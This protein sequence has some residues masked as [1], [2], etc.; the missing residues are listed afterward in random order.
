VTTG[1]PITVTRLGSDRVSV[2]GTPADCVRLALHHLACAPSWVLAG[3]NAG[4]N[5]GADI[6]HSGTV[7]AARE[8]AIHGVPAIAFSHYL[9]R[10]RSVDWSRASQW[11]SD[12][13]ARLLAQPWQP[14]TFWNVNLPHL[15]PHAPCPEVVVCPLDSSPLPLAYRLEGDQAIYAGDYQARARL[16]GGDIDVCFLGRIAVSL[17]H[18]GF[19]A[20]HNIWP[21]AAPT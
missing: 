20:D 11:V 21:I 16:P 8:A 1:S 7:A 19:H 6:Y 13:L 10:G 9:L 15:G 14:G 12:V 5:L 3:I 4:G 17:I 18:V 2:A